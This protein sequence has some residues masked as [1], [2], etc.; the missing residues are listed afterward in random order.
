MADCGHCNEEILPG[1]RAGSR[2]VPLHTECLIRMS[3]GSVAHQQ[4]TC[5][6]FGGTGEDPPTMTTREAAKA[7]ALL[8]EQSVIRRRKAGNN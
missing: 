6:C 7:A 1:E 3:V 4:K 2:G 8:F 5:S